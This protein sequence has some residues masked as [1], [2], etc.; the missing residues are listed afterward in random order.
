MMMKPD[1]SLNHIMKRET[2]LTKPRCYPEAIEF[3]LKSKVP[4]NPF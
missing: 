3:E 2:T 1:E 4:Y